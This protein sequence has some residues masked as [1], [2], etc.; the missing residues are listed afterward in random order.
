MGLGLTCSRPFASRRPQARQTSAVASPIRYQ[1]A[2]GDLAVRHIALKDRHGQFVRVRSL[3]GLDL[4]LD[5]LRLARGVRLG[6]VKAR[7]GLVKARVVELRLVRGV[8]LGL[9]KARVVERLGLVKARVVERLGLVKARVVEL[10][11]ARG[12]RLG[13]VARESA[14]R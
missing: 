8:R 1:R 11:L 2:R 6:L 10:R 5:K 14:R 12:V 3:H 13:L 4:L 7:L 9:V